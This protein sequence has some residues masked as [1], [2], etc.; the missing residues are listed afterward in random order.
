MEKTREKVSEFESTSY[1]STLPVTSAQF[2]AAVTQNSNTTEKTYPHST[3][4]SPNTFLVFAKTVQNNILNE[5]TDTTNGMFETSTEP[6]TIS[7]ATTIITTVRESPTE[8]TRIPLKMYR[9]QLKKNRPD[10][11]GN[12]L[13][14]K[15]VGGMN[16]H[17]ITAEVTE[18]MKHLAESTTKKNL[19]WRH[20]INFS[21][22]KNNATKSLNNTENSTIHSRL[23][24]RK[25]KVNFTTPTTDVSITEPT[26][27]FT[28]QKLSHNDISEENVTIIQKHRFKS[29][30]EVPVVTQSRAGIGN[31]YKNR[32]LSSSTVTENSA[33][34]STTTNPFNRVNSR[35]FARNRKTSS[36]ESIPTTTENIRITTSRG[37][38]I[39]NKFIPKGVIKT[40]NFDSNENNRN[41][42]SSTASVNTVSTIFDQIS[43]SNLKE[44]EKI[45]N[46]INLQISTVFDKFK[47]TKLSTELPLTTTEMN[48][49][50]SQKNQNLNTAIH[51][52]NFSNNSKFEKN[53]ETSSENIFSRINIRNNSRFLKNPEAEY[54]SSDNIKESKVQELKRYPAETNDKNDSPI[55]VKQ[56]KNETQIEFE[57]Q[58]KHVNNKSIKPNKNS[59]QP[60]S[61]SLN[62][63]DEKS[64]QPLQSRGKHR[65][66]DDIFDS[67][68]VSI[69]LTKNRDSSEFNNFASKPA[70]RLHYSSLNKEVTSVE[71]TT[72]R[73]INKNRGSIKAKNSLSKAEI[74]EFVSL[75]DVPSNKFS[76]HHQIPINKIEETS[77]FGNEFRRNFN[78]S[79]SSTKEKIYLPKNYAY[80]T[81]Y[82][83]PNIN[84]RIFEE[85]TDLFYEYILDENAAVT[86][87]LNANLI[88]KDVFR[89]S[90]TKYNNEK[91]HLRNDSWHIGKSKSQQNIREERTDEAEVWIYG[92][93]Y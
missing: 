89:V 22:V 19:L 3:A 55:F 77:N 16:R 56:K 91:I 45:L 70:T 57:I 78:S 49:S 42:H 75:I 79:R 88:A 12:D 18:E 9:E 58:V 36:T 53:F 61:R 73:M 67:N 37:R 69:N 26:S 31:F 54:L 66:S 80:S 34:N 39:K 33:D 44:E 43:S 51:I 27:N 76:N 93:G 23:F 74:K 68:A 46:K 82:T 17:K 32:R 48:E 65:F 83:L 47:E 60:K 20:R 11:T 84:D 38:F 59:E 85:T 62:F 72:K 25:N 29:R 90:E 8:K 35:Y 13:K 21:I 87:S 4:Y 10:S 50:S 92:Y 14:S 30:S 28:D 64:I 41:A 6:F 5:S 71:V 52:K 24:F 2:G 86:D 63:T 81:I 40:E 1:Q 7:V 15:V